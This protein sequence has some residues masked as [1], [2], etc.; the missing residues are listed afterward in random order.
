MDGQSPLGDCTVRSACPPLCQLVIAAL[1]L[2]CT[3]LTGDDMQWR[4]KQAPG[5]GS[6]PGQTHAVGDI[7]M[8]PG[9]GSQVAGGVACKSEPV[10]EGALD[11]ESSND[12]GVVDKEGLPQEEAFPA[13][14][15][16]CVVTA[17][18]PTSTSYLVPRP[19]DI[20]NLRS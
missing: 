10:S 14:R 19:L 6:T 7:K 4:G 17:S 2:G 3:V 9:G 15:I 5:W 20:A 12:N 1:H 18:P 11:V 13:L 16:I 8:E